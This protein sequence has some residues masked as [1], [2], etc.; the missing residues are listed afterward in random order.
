MQAF[1]EIANTMQ[2]V[3]AMAAD[4]DI[5]SIRKRLYAHIIE[6]KYAYNFTWYGRPIIQFPEDILALQEIILTVKPDL[7]LET[8]IAHGG[9]LI[10]SASM[11]ELLGG[12]RRVLGVD[13][14]IRE[15]NRIEIEKH[16]LFKRITMLQGS[17]VDRQIVETVHKIAAGRR[18]V[19]VILDSN[20]SHAHVAAE[21]EAYAGIVDKGSYLVV[22]DTVIE[23]VD[24][25]AFPDRNWGKGNNPKTAVRE[26][27][28]KND[29]F[30]VDKDIEDRLLIT[31][32]PGGYLKCVKDKSL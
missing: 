3:K 4:A 27:L 26:F 29:R 6:Y 21:L 10:F 8:G 1:P 15:H 25:G 16:P 5:Q 30:A 14:D 9:S 12:D 32:A 31:V 11:L 2:N 13:I 28:A 19:M 24:D 7:I 23:D 18:K 20:H 22:F 17:S